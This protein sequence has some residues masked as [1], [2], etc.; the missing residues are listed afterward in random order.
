MW[1]EG[2]EWIFFFIFWESG[3]FYFVGAYKREKMPISS[4]A[5]HSA[6]SGQKSERGRG[7]AEF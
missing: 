1:T 2:R 5:D 4:E 7:K 3:G 6:S